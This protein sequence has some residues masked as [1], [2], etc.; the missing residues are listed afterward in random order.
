MLPIKL[1]SPATRDFWEVAVL[2]VD[3][4]LL[5]V[6]KPS[7]LATAPNPVDPTQPSLL[8]LLHAGI[9]E[10]RPWAVQRRLAYLGNPYHLDAGVGGVLPLARSKEVFT[11]LSNHFHSMAPGKRFLALARGVPL[12]PRFEIEG[13]LEPDPRQPGIVR[14]NS[15]RGKKSKTLV[16][17]VETFKDYTLLR[18]DPL[19]GRPQQIRAHLRYARLPLVGD[20]LYGGR[21]LLLSR[22]KPGYRLKPGQL[23]RPLLAE[24]ALHARELALPHPVTRQ[25]LCLQAPIPKC[26]EVALR[27]L[28]RYGA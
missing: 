26:L 14:V 11:S 21:P 5:V 23:E 27:Y 6:D 9:R 8:G 3:E 4:H 28:R 16:E 20:A 24:P 22:L 12:E 13:K 17:V 19:P 1:S 25:P 18:C 2:Y 10:G 15:R 7:G